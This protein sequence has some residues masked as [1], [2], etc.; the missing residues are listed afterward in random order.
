MMGVEMRKGK[1]GLRGGRGRG[2]SRGG[3][4]SIGGL[5]EVVEEISEISEIDIRSHRN[6]EL[7]YHYPHKLVGSVQIEV[8]HR[9]H[10][11][12]K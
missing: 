7:R 4:G 5:V 11:L 2:G 10:H 8:A 6:K 3:H 9:R 12:P 1:E